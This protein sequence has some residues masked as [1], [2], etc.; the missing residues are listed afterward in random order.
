MNDVVLTVDPQTTVVPLEAGRFRALSLPFVIQLGQELFAEHPRLQHT[1]P[2]KARRL[3]MLLMSKD[4]ELNAAL[5][6]APTEHC[7]PDEVVSRFCALSVDVMAA[8]ASR[9]RSGD[10]SAVAAD[11]EVWRRLAA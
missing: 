11:R 4:P 2:E 5:F 9:Q 1:Q 10:L 7:R 8:L 3:A 6:V